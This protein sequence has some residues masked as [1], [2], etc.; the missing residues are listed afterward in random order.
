MK[1]LLS[2]LLT[3]LMILGSFVA[4]GPETPDDTKEKPSESTSDTLGND[5]DPS[6]A[7]T[8]NRGDETDPSDSTTDPSDSTT[9]NS[10][11]TDTTT[12]P[13]TTEG[14][15][16][17]VPEPGFETPDTITIKLEGGKANYKIIRPEDSTSA[18]ADVKKSGDISAVFADYIGKSLDLG[19]DSARKNDSSTLEI[20]IGVTDYDETAAVFD[21]IKYGEYI[22]KAVGNKIVIMGYTPDAIERAADEFIALCRSKRDRA[23]KTVTFTAEEFYCKGSTNAGLNTLPVLGGETRAVYYDAGIRTTGSSCDMMVINESNVNLY[24]E[25]LSKM[26]AAG[27]EQYVSTE[28]GKNKFA[29]YTKD[30][31]VVTLG[32]F[33]ND[34]TIRVTLEIGAPLTGL[35]SENQYTKVTTSQISMLGQELRGEDSGSQNGLSELI[36]LEDGRF[37]VIDGGHKGTQWKDAFIAEIKRQ[38]AECGNDKPV[39]AAWI[40]THPHSDHDAL[41]YA[42]AEEMK[43][44]GIT[45]ERVLMN[46]ITSQAEL[47]RLYALGSNSES[48]SHK[49]SIDKCLTTAS[50][51]GATVHK[52]HV[53]QVFHLANAKIEVLYT[54]ESRYP[55]NMP[56]E[57]D[58]S[59]VMKM[60]FTDSAT[61][62]ETTFLSTGDATGN[63]FD[64]IY[65]N[66]SSYIS[67]DILSLAHHGGET[68][69]NERNTK[70]A[71]LSVAPTLALWPIGVRE[72]IGRAH[73]NENK[74]IVND[75]LFAEECLKEIYI[76]GYVGDTTIIP[77]PYVE[78][79]VQG[80]YMWDAEN[81]CIWDVK[82]EE[83]LPFPYA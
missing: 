32:Y 73:R 33:P 21:E 31:Y 60:T 30:R 12:V 3:L 79:N 52:V 66:F 78:G 83:V 37:I 57:N 1:R 75:V 44:K 54:H 47:D 4:C 55:I 80:F 50:K 51:I 42:H 53:G 18:S 27:F 71:Y 6:D 2:L 65:N 7:T 34:K 67:C 29:T 77:L 19:T 70:N 28:M 68:G 74:K 13:G 36:R 15:L 23:T 14:P 45:V 48:I 76:A 24:T 43:N 56:N 35:E 69:G 26:E 61:G 49:S 17:Y 8:N 46:P 5:T 62:K 16:G 40:L 41:F 22:V 59:L 39:I 11:D 82:N 58:T 25:Y 38:A 72:G 64:N 9:D 81:E 10:G 20:L 63:A